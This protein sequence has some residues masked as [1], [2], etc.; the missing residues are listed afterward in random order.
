MLDLNK[1]YF[2]DECHQNVNV[3][4]VLESNC[5]WCREQ[6]LRHKKDGGKVVIK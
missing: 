5:P 6:Q 2:C 3:N 1:S 4:E